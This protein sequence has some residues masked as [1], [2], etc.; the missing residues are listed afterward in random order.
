MFALH[1]ALAA[2]LLLLTERA[3]AFDTAEGQAYLDAN[4]AR[5]GVVVTGSGLQYRVIASGGADAPS[6]GLDDPCDCEYEGHL[7]NGETFDSGRATFAPNQVIGGWTEALQ[8][9]RTGDEW[10]LTI[11]SDLAYGARG[12]PPSIP[13]HA[14]LVFT[15]TLLEIQPATAWDALA[16]PRLTY[17]LVALFLAL[18]SALLC[19]IA[20]TAF[21]L[22][23]TSRARRRDPRYVAVELSDQGRA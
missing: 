8:L 9:M 5:E 6:P 2:I 19:A 17:V 11:P 13:V 21:R 14:V 4:A 18:L 20:A 3:C 23:A 22:F 10:E 15:L 1:V 16:S 12:A 7:I